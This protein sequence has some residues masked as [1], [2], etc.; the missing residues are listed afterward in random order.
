MRS[1]V[2]SADRS[3]RELHVR[4]LR[5]FD[6]SLR[7]QDHHDVL[8]QA[9]DEPGFVGGIQ[10][11]DFGFS[12]RLLQ[13]LC[14]EYLRRLRQYHTL[15]RNG[16]RDD[17]HIFRQAGRFT[18][19]TVSIAG[20]PSMAAL[21]RRACSITRVT[22]STVTNGRTAS[23]TTTSSVSSPTSFKAAAPTLTR[24]GALH[25]AHRLFETFPA[26]MRAFSGSTFSARVA[27]M[28]SEISG[29][30]AIR[31]RLR[32]TIGTPSSSRN[33][34]GV[35]APMRVPSPA[36][37]RMATM[38]LMVESSPAEAECPAGPDAGL[39]KIECTSTEG[40]KRNPAGEH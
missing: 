25:H 22:C 29:Q 28:I 15:T 10:S 39:Q 24:V 37:G 13:Q 30:A 35:S 19:F 20:I 4:G 26:L 23:C 21:W 3:A 5:D 27:T 32:I 7:P 9:L 6:I 38:W 11:I 1:F 17:R 40:W 18:S 2:R 34:L 16:S 31:R 8:P 33:C 36:A 12:K 14:L